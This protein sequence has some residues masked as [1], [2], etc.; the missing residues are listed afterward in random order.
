MNNVPLFKFDGWMDL[1][2]NNRE[3]FK[4]ERLYLKVQ[5]R[6]QNSIS[7]NIINQPLSQS[8][9]SLQ[10]SQSLLPMHANQNQ[11]NPNYTM[12]LLQNM[13]PGKSVQ[14]LNPNKTIN[15][16]NSINAENSLNQKNSMN[17]LN[18]INL[19]SPSGISIQKKKGSD[20]FFEGGKSTIYKTS[21]L[22]F[23]GSEDRPNLSVDPNKVD[24]ID[25]TLIEQGKNDLHEQNIS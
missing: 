23:V 8:I 25:I 2:H 15:S 22:K 18:Y 11:S 20:E 6:K 10:G 14:S 24:G 19:S 7:Q 17:S 4:A 3:S 21:E 16:F 1:T 12:S 9:Q 5:I 13:Y